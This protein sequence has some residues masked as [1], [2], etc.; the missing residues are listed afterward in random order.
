MKRTIY[1]V[2]FLLIGYTGFGQE[3]SEYKEKARNLI[4]LTSAGQFDVLVQPLINMVPQE[5]RAAFK[6]DIQASMD[7]LYDQLVMVYMDAYTE[8]EID[9]IMAF[10]NTPVGKKMVAKTPE[11]TQR[12]MQI[13]Q[14]WG[15]KLQPLIR[16]YSN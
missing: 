8:E 10:Y 16:K 7:E 3:K 13:G 2:A 14:Q 15:M 5:K 6:A 4:E 9:A 11:I 12:S 1:F